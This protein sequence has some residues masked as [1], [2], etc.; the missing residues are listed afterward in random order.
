[1][2]KRLLA[3]TM[4][5]FEGACQSTV[6]S[7]CPPLVTYS[8]AQMAEA[9]KELRLSGPEVRRLVTDYGKLRDGCRVP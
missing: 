5:L 8:R 1:M 9:A 6:V 7:G 3:L 2:K 4:V